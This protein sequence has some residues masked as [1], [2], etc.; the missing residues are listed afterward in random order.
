M[1]RKSKLIKPSL[2]SKMTMLIIILI[3]S[4]IPNSLAQK[5]H[6]VEV[7]ELYNKKVDYNFNEE[8]Q[9]LTTDLYI[10]NMDKIEA[11]LDGVWAGEKR[12]KK[13]V[14]SVFI[15]AELQGTILNDISY[16]LYNFISNENDGRIQTDSRDK[17]RIMNNYPVSSVSQSVSAVIKM[18]II[19]KDKENAV[20]DFVSKQL[21]NISGYSTP[22]SAAKTLTGELSNLMESRIKNTKYEFSSTI[23]IYKEDFDKKLFSVGVYMFQPEGNNEKPNITNFVNDFDSEDINKNNIPNFISGI[24]YPYLVSVNYKSKYVSPLNITSEITDES[25]LQRKI[26][27][28]AKY[29]GKELNQKLYSQEQTLN[30]F[31]EEYVRLQKAEKN[32]SDNKNRTNQEGKNQMQLDLIDS[33]KTF[34]NLYCQ[35]ITENEDDEI[36]KDIFK[37]HYDDVLKLADKNMARNSELKNI[38]EIVKCSERY[39]ENFQQCF[40]NNDIERD[41]AILRS[42]RLPQESDFETKINSLISKIEELYYNRD[43]LPLMSK[44][45]SANNQQILAEL[46]NKRAVT[47]CESCKPKLTNAIAQYDSQIAEEQKADAI[48]KMQNLKTQSR[49]ALL[50]SQNLTEDIGNLQQYSSDVFKS[51]V[52]DLKKKQQKLQDLVNKDYTNAGTSTIEDGIKNIENAK[53][54]VESQ[55]LQIKNQFEEIKKNN[56]T[57]QTYNYTPANDSKTETHTNTAEPS[58][59]TITPSN[60]FANSRIKFNEAVSKWQNDSQ[61]VKEKILKLQNFMSTNDVEFSGEEES[62][63]NSLIKEFQRLDNISK[64]NISSL[65]PYQLA[66]KTDDLTTASKELVRKTDIFYNEFMEG[67]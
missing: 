62:Q 57:T 47:N 4:I 7:T 14:K 26:D 34:Y 37:L 53:F 58:Q 35:R 20:F 5:P 12:G 13:I 61:K 60:D 3:V 8:W 24:N 65:T 67:F 33:Y 10:M 42:V 59:F 45:G 31:L 19:T 63:Y 49:S 23:D 21:K 1:E 18:E 66:Q 36:F 17:V 22:L 46:K 38:M 27:I 39:E 28:K 6:N 41:L 64:E 51:N 25:V 15:S 43:F 56:P 11:L 40:D 54:D 55:T 30:Q 29:D 48:V 32:Y 52:E 44:L 2:S 9:Y 16:P 50:T